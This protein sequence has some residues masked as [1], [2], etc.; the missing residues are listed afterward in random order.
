MVAR[1]P[2]ASGGSGALEFQMNQTKKF[3]ILGFL[4]RGKRKTWERDRE[5]A[6]G[7]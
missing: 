1:T 7:W 4:K 5:S 2:A 6:A 3:G